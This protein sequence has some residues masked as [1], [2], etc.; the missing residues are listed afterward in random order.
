VAAVP[1]DI[2]PRSHTEPRS[3]PEGDQVEVE[4]VLDLDVLVES[5]TCSC[6]AGDDNPY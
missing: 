4:V 6:N 2:Q 5:S 1:V 3:A